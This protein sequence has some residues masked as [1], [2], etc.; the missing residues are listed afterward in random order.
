MCQT[1]SKRPTDGRT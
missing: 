1:P